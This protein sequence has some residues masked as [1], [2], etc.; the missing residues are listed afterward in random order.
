[1]DHDSNFLLPENS[2]SYKEKYDYFIN[3]IPNF[4]K[5]NITLLETL[6]VELLNSENKSDLEMFISLFFLF[7]KNNVKMVHEIICLKFSNSN[8]EL[9]VKISKALIRVAAT[10][11][12][13]EPEQSIMEL[14]VNSID[15]YNSKSSGLFN[16]GKF[17]MG[18]FSIL[19]WLT[20]SQNGD[21]SRSVIIES[22]FNKLDKI[23]T[24]FCYLNWTPDGL[25]CTTTFSYPKK[26]TGTKISLI[27]ESHQLTDLN[28]QKM[29]LYINK[30]SFMEN[31]EIKCNSVII[32]QRK[33]IGSKNKINIKLTTSLIEVE[34]F[35]YGI[36]YD[37]I[38]SSMLIPTSS[39]K[40]RS[41][42]IPNLI[43]PTIYTSVDNIYKLRIFV[44]N[45]CIIELEMESIELYGREYHIYLPHNSKVPVSREDV[46]Y[47]NNSIEL[48]HFRDSVNFL[49]V[50]SIENDKNIYYLI[51]LIKKY[52]TINKSPYLNSIVNN[53]VNQLSK[54][55]EIFVIYNDFW[56]NF[57]SNIKLAVNIVLYD[58]S[59]IFD[60]EEKF[61]NVIRNTKLCNDKIFD[62]RL[63]ISASFLEKGIT[64]NGGFVSIIFIRN[65]NDDVRNSILSFRKSMLIPYGTNYDD[66][67]FSIYPTEFRKNLILLY[68][69]FKKKTINFY[70]SQ[71]SLVLQRTIE[72]IM[73]Y[74]F[75]TRFKKMILTLTTSKIADAEFKVV[76]PNNFYILNRP[77]FVYSSWENFDYDLEQ[78]YISGYCEKLMNFFIKCISS[79]HVGKF[80]LPYYKDFQILSNESRLIYQYQTLDDQCIGEAELFILNFVVREIEITLGGF[81]KMLI[82]DGFLC[83]ILDEI[84]KITNNFSLEHEILSYHISCSNDIKN[85]ITT[86][87]IDRCVISGARFLT[88][89]NK[90]KLSRGLQFDFS[91]E[92]TSCKYLIYKAFIGDN[93]ALKY[94]KFNVDLMPLQIV[95]IAVNDGTNKLFIQSVMT[96]LIQNSLDA[97]KSSKNEKRIDINIGSNYIKIK[98]RC[99][100]RDIL[101]I[102]IPFLSDKDP[103]DPN[104]TGEIGTGFFNVFRQPFTKHVKI[105]TCYNGVKTI[106]YCVPIL[107]DG[108]VIDIEYHITKSNIS[109]DCQNETSAD[110]NCDLLEDLNLQ[111]STEITVILNDNLEILNS[112]IIEAYLFAENFISLIEIVDV[113]IGD[114]KKNIELIDVY[115]VE[116]FGKFSITT[117]DFITS[118]VLTN[119]VPFLFMSDI[120]IIDGKL[121]EI[122]EKFG[123]TSIVLNLDKNVYIPSQSRNKITIYPDLLQEFNSFIYNGLIRCIY[124]KYVLDMINLP[125]EIIDHTNSVA[126]IFHL[127]PSMHSNILAEYIFDE[128]STDGIYRSVS[129]SIHFIIDKF[130]STQFQRL[131]DINNMTLKENIIYKWFS[132]K[133]LKL[134]QILKTR[135]TNTDS[136]VFTSPVLS[137]FT[138]VY[139]KKIKFLI[140]RGDLLGLNLGESPEVFF[141]ILNDSEGYYDSKN[142]KIALSSNFFNRLN[143]ESTITDLSSKEINYLDFH[144]NI[145]MLNFFSV[146]IPA[147]TFIHEITHAVLNSPCTN[148]ESIHGKVKAIVNGKHNL[149]FD[150]F[151]ITVYTL[152][153]SN[154][155]FLD[156]FTELKGGFHT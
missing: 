23:V 38:M 57:I 94:N 71:T 60:A 112:T 34:D 10:R 76:Y 110:V 26:K 119:D 50:R 152:C 25:K 39:T 40:I 81:S 121:L 115:E 150:E 63:V 149:D 12:F 136:Q 113:Y 80:V 87:I 126:N 56:I 78:I 92:V 3:N 118:F 146:G 52:V 19:Y 77:F 16:I 109:N 104:V 135:P 46:I 44:S 49:I 79:V 82:L 141:M 83:Y 9:G 5:S 122:F 147:C 90:N 117:N 6:K 154:N 108:L 96:E 144:E 64:E 31:V 24:Y 18:F 140:D 120:S 67:K 102:L 27:C 148:N 111:N 100:I 156:F 43:L 22:S 74:N 51:S 103:N 99:G 41:I 153:I 89:K 48:Q 88:L 59:L 17:G 8:T 125:D 128:L 58:N 107:N 2:M 4:D 1:M 129:E 145:D 130:K 86:K 155:L 138:N 143:I 101:Q 127:Y 93:I 65:H 75:S 124:K 14:P 139:W 68:M 66:S 30:L 21:Y 35:A 91:G 98:D 37:L 20:E 70:N 62:S 54:R 29:L 97:I 28:V 116:S 61:K 53:L 114:E 142:N 69:T 13:S 132:N 151:A 84:R 11:I 33:S 72:S 45:T 7:H 32:N 134:V 137:V 36:E 15:S 106:V 55:P 73:N 42:D 133:D 95:E 105:D 131:E 47:D 85:G 123:T